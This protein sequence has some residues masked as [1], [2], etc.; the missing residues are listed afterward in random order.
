MTAWF[1]GLELRR[2]RFDYWAGLA[3]AGSPYLYVEELDGTGLRD[4]LELKPPEMWAGHECDVPFR[5]WSLG[6]EAHGVLLDDPSDVLRRPYGTVVPVAFDVEWYATDGPEGLEVPPG[7]DGYRQR[8]EFDARIETVDG[9]LEF[10]G[11]SWRLHQWGAPYR[12][13][14]DATAVPNPAGLAAPL[15]RGDGTGVL[16]WFTPSGWEAR[17]VL[18]A[19]DARGG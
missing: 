7:S 11:P 8:G 16:Q 1:V 17:S 9:L 12:P 10:A 5:Q 3:R 6:N 15:R 2:R 13:S 19:D 18:L 14:L 4:G